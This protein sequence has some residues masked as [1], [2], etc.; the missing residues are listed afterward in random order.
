MDDTYESFL[1][2]EARH[3][4]INA[5]HIFHIFSF[6]KVSYRLSVA[7]ANKPHNCDCDT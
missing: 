3:H 6:S 4:A 7:F 2:G 1:F 5:P